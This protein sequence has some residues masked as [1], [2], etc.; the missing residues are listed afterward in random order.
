MS[1]SHQA[2]R[3]ARLERLLF[4]EVPLTRV[5]QR[6]IIGFIFV[7]L[8]F[9]FFQKRGPHK[10]GDANKFMPRCALNFEEHGVRYASLD[11]SAELTGS[12]FGSPCTKLLMLKR[13]HRLLYPCTKLI[14]CHNLQFVQKMIKWSVQ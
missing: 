7:S 14:H 8:P 13:L 10:V 2:Y 11:R 5:K 6:L 3:H 1:E 4:F 9:E 12:Q